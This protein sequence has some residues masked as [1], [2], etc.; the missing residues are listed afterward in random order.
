MMHVAGQLASSRGIRRYRM[1]KLEVCTSTFI[2]EVCAARNMQEDKMVIR[3]DLM[4]MFVQHPG[5][6]HHQQAN[7]SSDT[8]RRLGMKSKSNPIE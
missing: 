2:Q 5:H 1:L 7:K 8:M 4:N 6:Y 3:L